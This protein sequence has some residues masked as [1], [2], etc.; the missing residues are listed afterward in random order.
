M[1]SAIMGGMEWGM[2][3]RGGLSFL[4]VGDIQQKGE[5]QNFGNERG[6]SSVFLSEKYWSPIRS[7]LR[8]VLTEMIL[9]RVRE[10]FLSKQ[11][12][13]FSM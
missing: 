1:W 11:Q 3:K 8:N 12:K 7:T 6:V 9:K 5:V 2:K 4:V 10:Y 13:I